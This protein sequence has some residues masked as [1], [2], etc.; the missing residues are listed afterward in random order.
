MAKKSENVLELGEFVRLLTENQAVIRGYIRSLIPNASD[1]NDVLQNTN[2]ALWERRDQFE[3]GTNFRAW[4][5]VIA[6]Y[7]ALEHRS[8]LKKRN[9]LIFD[10]ELVNILA[11]EGVEQKD[12]VE[13][14]RLALDG[15]LEKLSPQNASLIRARYH[16]NIT[17]A[18]YSLEDGRSPAS[19][20][21]ILNR[22][23]A[24]LRICIE[25]QLQYL[26]KQAQY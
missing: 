20:R 16:R 1:I 21:V 19:L 10:D 22:L 7:R 15:C 2:L 9:V 25:E 13:L 17:L 18:D 23:R 3:P 8:R 4:A 14:E 6:R 5:C 12:E 24:S 11:D 26:R